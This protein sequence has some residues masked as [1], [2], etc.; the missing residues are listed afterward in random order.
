MKIT[1]NHQ[2]SNLY[3]RLLYLQNNIPIN[4]IYTKSNNLYYKY[5][6]NLEDSHIN[7]ISDNSLDNSIDN[8]LLFINNPINFV[9]QDNT[10]IDKFI[11]KV[12]FF[13]DDQILSM[14]KE[15]LYIFNEQTTKYEK[16]SFDEKVCDAI[17]NVNYIQYGFKMPQSILKER[18]K[19]ILFIPSDHNLDNVIFTQIKNAYPDADVIPDNIVDIN[20][21]FLN[22]K[23]C[24]CTNSFYN[25]LLAAAHGCIIVSPRNIIDIPHHYQATNLNQMMSSIKNVLDNYD[26][27]IHQQV[28]SAVTSRYDYDKFSNTIKHIILNTC[29]KVVI[30]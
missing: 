25:S 15:D 23:V 10:K 29:K 30:I 17:P 7:F 16:Y 13:H 26:P 12:M 18:K 20:S 1:N 5:L 8:Q 21:L 28:S 3:K 24:V 22:Y 27:I 2:I 14:K 6:P 4:V 11:P 19:S 9:Q